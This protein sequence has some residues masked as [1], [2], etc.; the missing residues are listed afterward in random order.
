MGTKMFM[1]CEI[2]YKINHPPQ[3]LLLTF[4]RPGKI[5]YLLKTTKKLSLFFEGVLLQFLGNRI[6]YKNIH[7]ILY[8]TKSFFV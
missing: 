4:T 6:F 3:L 1:Q 2:T 5:L 7:L 8:G